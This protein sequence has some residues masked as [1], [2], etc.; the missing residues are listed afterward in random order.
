MFLLGI[1][2]AG[3]RVLEVPGYGE[4]AR[5]V[6]GKLYNEYCDHYSGIVQ[7]AE[8]VLSA[9]SFLGP[10]GIV[11]YNVSRLMRDGTTATKVE[12]AAPRSPTVTNGVCRTARAARSPIKSGF[13]P[14]L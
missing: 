6:Y 10:D 14:R 1:L 4:D 13:C 9:E 7:S 5:H 2:I 8:P 12:P 11:R 3:V